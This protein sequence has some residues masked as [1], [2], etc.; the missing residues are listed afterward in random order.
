MTWRWTQ[1][2]ETVANR[3]NGS[4]R[5][6][7]TDFDDWEFNVRKRQTNQFYNNLPRFNLSDLKRLL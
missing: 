5:R 2:W 7:S 3:A 4:S 6:W 1:E